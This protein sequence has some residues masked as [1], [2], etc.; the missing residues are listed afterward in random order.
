MRKPVKNFQI[1]AQA[2]LQV[3]KTIKNGYFWGGVCDRGTAQMAQFRATGIISAT[4]WLHCVRHIHSSFNIIRK[5]TARPLR[6]CIALDPQTHCNQ[7]S[8]VYKAIY[9][10]IC[11]QKVCTWQFLTTVSC[12]MLL[13]GIRN[14]IICIMCCKAVFVGNI[15]LSYSTFNI[16]KRRW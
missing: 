2:V 12:C 7:S 14:R 5:E 11:M 3:S 6:V 10:Y 9:F 4:S 13:T 1:S 16:I 8:F 15:K